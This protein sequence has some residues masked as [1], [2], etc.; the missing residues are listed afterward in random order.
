MPYQPRFRVCMALHAVTGMVTI[1]KIL[2]LF[3]IFIMGV[4]LGIIPGSVLLGYFVYSNFGPC[5]MYMDDA[6]FIAGVDLTTL[7]WNV[8]L[9]CY[10]LPD[11]IQWLSAD[12]P[13]EHLLPSTP[14]LENGS[15]SH[16][17]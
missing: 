2:F 11:G 17:G 15:S 6:V 10:I 16:S 4:F 12:W 13:E 8:A 3:L 9:Q 7:E 1:I 14:R 5:L